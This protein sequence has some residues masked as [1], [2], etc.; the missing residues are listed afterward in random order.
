[1][2][3]RAVDRSTDLPDANAVASTLP[4]V[5]Q[6]V[7][8]TALRIREGEPRHDPPCLCR[9]AVLDCGLEPLAERFGLL[10]LT[11]EPAE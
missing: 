8:V 3:D 6:A 11:P 5:D 1:V 9:I 7:D 4:I 10:Q 2:L